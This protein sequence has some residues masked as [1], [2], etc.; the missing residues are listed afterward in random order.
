VRL[1]AAGRET[2]AAEVDADERQSH[3]ERQ[4]QALSRAQQLV[5]SDELLSDAAWR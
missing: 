5:D 1:A 2:I 3:R 4:L